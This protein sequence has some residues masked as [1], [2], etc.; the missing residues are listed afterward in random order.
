MDTSSTLSVN[1]LE[2]LNAYHYTIITSWISVPRNSTSFDS[3]NSSKGEDDVY[4]LMPNIVQISICFVIMIP[5]HSLSLVVKHCSKASKPLV[6]PSEL[7]QIL[8]DLNCLLGALSYAV[9]GRQIYHT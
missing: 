8:G 9:S 2:A 6:I 4:C 1:I 7:I 3:H 5:F